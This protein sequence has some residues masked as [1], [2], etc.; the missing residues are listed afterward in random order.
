MSF[1]PPLPPIR[2]GTDLQEDDDDEQEEGDLYEPPPCD[3][4]SR[5]PPATWTSQSPHSRYLGTD[6]GSHVRSHTAF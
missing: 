2:H 5:T 3:L 6:R 4:Q 1:L